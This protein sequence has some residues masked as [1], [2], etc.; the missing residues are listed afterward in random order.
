MIA[1]LTIA[2]I[3]I[4]IIFIRI[5]IIGEETQT[6]IKYAQPIIF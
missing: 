5:V 2:I 1:I 6:Q 4:I 3:K